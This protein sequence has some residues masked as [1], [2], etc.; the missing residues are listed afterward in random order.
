MANLYNGSKPNW[1]PLLR[2]I[3]LADPRFPGLFG[4]L[5]GPGS[6][7]WMCEN[8]VG[9]HQYKHRDT[10]NYAFLRQDSDATECLFQ[11]SR[12][13]CDTCTWSSLCGD[14]AAM[15]EGMVQHA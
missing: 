12:A 11:L 5:Q 13:E 10:R 7:M 14:H 15:R 4:K 8:P 3:D 9:V 2:A 6:Y 1:S